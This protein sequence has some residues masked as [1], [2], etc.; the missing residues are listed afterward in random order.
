[1]ELSW[2]WFPKVSIIPGSEYLLCGVCGGS[3]G[4]R[5]LT[6]PSFQL[7]QVREGEDTL[8]SGVITERRN[9]CVRINKQEERQNPLLSSSPALCK[10]IS[11]AAN[12]A[13]ASRI[14]RLLGSS[15]GTG[16][17]A[18]GC[19]LKLEQE[20]AWRGSGH[21][22]LLPSFCLD[23]CSQRLPKLWLYHLP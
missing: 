6:N 5:R 7:P 20:S 1:M 2:K 18:Q 15:P 22:C 17:W 12:T 3:R 21:S 4:L 8:T 13:H 11:L 19:A 14:H 9:S 23:S 10:H 16:L